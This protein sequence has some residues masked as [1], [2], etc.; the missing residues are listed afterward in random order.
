[1]ATDTRPN[2]T[3]LKAIAGIGMASLLFAV[4]VMSY[5]H[6][7][8]GSQPSLK[9]GDR[10]EFSP[11]RSSAPAPGIDSFKPRSAKLSTR[12]KSGKI[13]VAATKEDLSDLEVFALT[14]NSQGIAQ[15]AIRGRVFMVAQN[16]FVQVKERSLGPNERIGHYTKH[17]IT[18]MDGPNKGTEGWVPAGFLH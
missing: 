16:T 8:G 12:S 1:M 9:A 18:I 11:P 17:R 6:A 4:V 14:D 13:P 7:T 2:Y 5:Y 3:P 10:R 15:L